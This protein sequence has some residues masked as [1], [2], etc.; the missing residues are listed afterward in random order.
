MTS[1]E[2][3]NRWWHTGAGR[4]KFMREYPEESYPPGTASRETALS[5]FGFLNGFEAAQKT[6][7]PQEILDSIVAEAAEPRA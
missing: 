1:F 3:F 4:R 7:T 6:K 2:I 5:M